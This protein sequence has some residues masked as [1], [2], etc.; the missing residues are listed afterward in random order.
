MKAKQ[1]WP[2]VGDSVWDRI[3]DEFGML[4]EEQFEQHVEALFGDAEPFLERG[5]RVF[6]GDDT[7]FPGF[8]LVRGMPDRVVTDLFA[9]AMDL[10]IP[11]NVF[12]AWMVTP[13]RPRFDR[14]IDALEHPQILSDILDAFGH[15]RA[16]VAPWDTAQ[17][18]AKP[19]TR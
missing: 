8:Q 15:G 14:P 12:A 17:P 16:W 3:R 19:R 11:H 5:V 7:F 10:K 2:D 13:V 9:Q 1:S 6:I 4:T 18:P